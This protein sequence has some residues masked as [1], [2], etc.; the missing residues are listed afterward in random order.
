MEKTLTSLFKVLAGFFAGLAGT[1][2]QII[3]STIAVVGFSI[4]YI[5]YRILRKRHLADPEFMSEERRKKQEYVKR[6]ENEK[7]K[8][9]EE[10]AALEAMYESE[11]AYYQDDDSEPETDNVDVDETDEN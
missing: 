9:A 11:S 2:V 6:V 5:A 7:R 1:K 8:Q 10:N 3:V 4:S